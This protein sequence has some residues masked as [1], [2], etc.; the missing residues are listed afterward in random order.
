[1]RKAFGKAIKDIR[2]FRKQHQNTR[3]EREQQQNRAEPLFSTRR[4]TWKNRFSDGSDWGKQKVLKETWAYVCKQMI[5]Q[6]PRG[7]HAVGCGGVW[8]ECS[9]LRGTQL[10]NWMCRSLENN[11]F[12]SNFDVSRHRDILCAFSCKRVLACFSTDFDVVRWLSE[13]QTKHESC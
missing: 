12:Q 9:W 7:G 11:Y 4:E 10:I 8:W 6:W 1:M 2:H 3:K 5:A 13:I